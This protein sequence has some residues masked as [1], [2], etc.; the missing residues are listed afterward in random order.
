MFILHLFQGE[1]ISYLAFALGSPTL[2]VTKGELQCRGLGMDV[3]SYDENGKP[4][5]GKKENSYAHQ[6]FPQCL[7]TF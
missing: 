4:I 1:Q 7:C 2:E 6:H 3:H 5:I